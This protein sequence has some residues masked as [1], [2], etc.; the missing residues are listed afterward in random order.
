M[1]GTTIKAYL[2]QWKHK[3]IVK[4]FVEL[5]LIYLVVLDP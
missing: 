3:G 5:G 4:L 2:K 1:G